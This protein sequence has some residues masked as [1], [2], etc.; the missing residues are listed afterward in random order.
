MNLLSAAKEAV[1]RWIA[2][3]LW[4]LLAMGID[5][6]FFVV[7]GFTTAP[8]NDKIVEHIILI[9]SLMGQSAETTGAS[10]VQNGRSIIVML[11]SEPQIAPYVRQ[12]AWLF[13]LLALASF[14]TYVLFQATSWF[15]AHRCAGERMD[16]PT[17][18]ARFTSLNIWWGILF[19]GYSVLSLLVSLRAAIIQVLAARSSDALA[20]TLTAAAVFVAVLAVWT[21][22]LPMDPSGW[23]GA[24][25]GVKWTFRR[26]STTVPA[27]AMVLAVFVII[28]YIV[29][30]L[31]SLSSMAS[32]AVG[33]VLVLVALSVARLFLVLVGRHVDG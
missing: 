27:T 6:L 12:L 1:M 11:I 16:L 24:V 23:R 2:A 19:L 26:W 13:A 10:A 21:Y 31:S 14:V 20:W 9:G 17:F 4:L 30:G 32:L 29:V 33:A 3:P 5:A 18:M 8:I 7:Y 25:D 22:A 15:I 28:N